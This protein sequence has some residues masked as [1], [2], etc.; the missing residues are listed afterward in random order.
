[1]YSLI[2]LV[3]NCQNLNY[4][5]SLYPIFFESLIS[6]A[7][8]AAVAQFLKT[9]CTHILFIDS[10]I[11]FDP[12][13]IS[14]LFDINEEVVCAPYPKKYFRFE[15]VKKD[16]EI[17][18]FAIFGKIQKISETLCEIEYAASGFLL[19]KKEVFTKILYSK[20]DL[21]YINDV[22]AY[23]SGEKMWN[24]FQVGV[25][26]NTKLYNSEDWG[27]CELWK[28]IGG[29]IYARTDIKLIHWGWQGYQGDFNKWI[30]LKFKN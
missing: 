20:N 28:S 1:M 4:E 8:N 17:V 19:I 3:V 2:N 26:N 7:R 18:D 30:N 12:L 23:G 11:S 15:N 24:F 22:D 27:F 16:E 14:K 9:D 29:K 10:D 6:R 21:E 13:D 25:N 5:I